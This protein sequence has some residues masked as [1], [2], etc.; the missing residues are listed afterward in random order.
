M[1]HPP[2]VEINVN[3]VSILLDSLQVAEHTD[4]LVQLL[5]ARDGD[6]KL[7]RL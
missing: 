6:K 2:V 3:I 5:L 1:L 4:T 7:Q